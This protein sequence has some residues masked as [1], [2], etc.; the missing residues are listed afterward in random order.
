MWLLAQQRSVS[1]CVSLVFTRRRHYGALWLYTGVCHASFSLII[2]CSFFT[3][4]RNFAMDTETIITSQKVHRKRQAGSKLDKKKKKTPSDSNTTA[5][6]RN[7]KAFAYHSVNKVARQ[8]RRLVEP[9][10]S[11]Q[12][13][14]MMIVCLY[15]FLPYSTVFLSCAC[16]SLFSPLDK[17]A[18][19]SIYFFSC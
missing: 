9:Y 18:D 13:A 5:R 8:V 12:M 6:Q 3:D 7:P 17:P 10:C 11:I 1:K 19:R 4:I 16:F 15:G 14:N 2:F